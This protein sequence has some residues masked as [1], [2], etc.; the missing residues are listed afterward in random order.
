VQLCTGLRWGEVSA[1]R[2]EDISFA[3]AGS[4]RQVNLHIVRAWS[5]RSPEDTA[6][7]RWDQRENVSWIPGTAQERP[8]PLGRPH[9]ADRSSAGTRRRGRSENDYVFETRHANPWRYPDFYTDRWRPAR[10]PP[11]RHGLTRH[12]TPHMLRH[13]A[14]VWSLAEGVSIQVISEMIGHASLQMTYDIYGG[15]I[16]LRDGAGGGASRSAGNRS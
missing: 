11:A 8:G 3:G 2:I 5:R 7:I 14:V 9:R 10:D 6:P 15:L 12:V 13:T 16:N 4:D 1:L